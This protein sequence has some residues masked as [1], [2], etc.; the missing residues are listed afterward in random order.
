MKELPI[1]GN[2]AFIALEGQVIDSVTVAVDA[3]PDND[4]EANW[5][6]LGVIE[7]AEQS[8][9]YEG[10]QTHYAPQPGG[11]APRRRTF[12]STAL[13]INLLCQDMGEF[14]FALGLGATQPDAM[15][16]FV[17]GSLKGPQRGWLKIQQ[18]LAESDQ[19]VN[20]MDLWVE[21]KVSQLT[22]S[23]QVTKPSLE[24]FMLQ[25]SLNVGKL[26]NLS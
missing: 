8:V 17:P 16:N 21:M 1:I 2:H 9:S 5:T 10:E 25:S 14:L 26:S 12:E 11:Y 20:V 24:C 18:Y 22:T 3:K 15:G 7:Q 6:N 4:P 23:R 19:L 13:S